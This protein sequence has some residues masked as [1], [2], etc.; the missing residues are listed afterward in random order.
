MRVPPVLVSACL[1]AAAAGRGGGGGGE[2]RAARPP[3]PVVL[4]VTSPA[5]TAV[6][7]TE[8]V[9]VRGSVEP[10]DAAVRVLGRTADVHGGRFRVRVPLEPGANVIDVI[11]TARG[12]APAM[13]AFRVTREVPV[14]VPD[15]EGLEVPEL[16]QALADAGLRSEVTEDHGLFDE[17]LPGE[18]AACEQD[19]PAGARVRR[20]TVVRVTVAKR[21]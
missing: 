10:A 20:G 17:L 11:A 5:D 6:V 15:V 4:E 16:E 13:T 3:A 21:C 14:E 2:P 7:R 9:T 12:R 8:T 19:P 1:A 18:P